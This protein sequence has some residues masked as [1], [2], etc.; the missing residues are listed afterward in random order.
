MSLWHCPEHG[1]TGPRPCCPQA[2]FA[3]IPEPTVEQMA[4]L[5][6][7]VE[8]YTKLREMTPQALVNLALDHMPDMPYPYEQV[9][10]EL[11]TRVYPN[12]SNE[13]TPTAETPVEYRQTIDPPGGWA[14][15]TSK[16]KGVKSE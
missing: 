14:D 9:V 2:S 5:T 6:D 3:T 10:E 8:A 7:A 15:D 12:W 4:R 13:D 16:I 1:L 11:C